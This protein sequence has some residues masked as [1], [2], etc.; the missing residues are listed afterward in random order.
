MAILILFSQVCGNL[1]NQQPQITVKTSS[2]T[3]TGE[4][5]TGLELFQCTIL[6]EFSLPGLSTDSLED[7][8]GNIFI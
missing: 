4:E 5:R 7:R 1:E 2:L 6:R 3:A 8:T